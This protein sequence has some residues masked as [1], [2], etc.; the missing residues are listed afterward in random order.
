MNSNK[1]ITNLILSPWNWCKCP[2]ASSSSSSSSSSRSSCGGWT[3]AAADRTN[4][5]QAIRQHCR[6][7]FAI[8]AWSSL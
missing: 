2:K 4:W 6:Q 3:Q 7:G 5:W 8:S 1:F